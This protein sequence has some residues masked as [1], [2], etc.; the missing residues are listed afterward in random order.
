MEK[1][2]K[3]VEAH[4]Y[5]RKG[6]RRNT[7]EREEKKSFSPKCFGIPD[8]DASSIDAAVTLNIA[9]SLTAA[10]IPRPFEVSFYMFVMYLGDR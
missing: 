10:L 8:A 2:Q 4:V 9:F 3:K 1:E 5:Q 6:T 7:E